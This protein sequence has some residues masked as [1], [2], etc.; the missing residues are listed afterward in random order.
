MKRLD[1]S[2]SWFELKKNLSGN[3]DLEIDLDKVKLSKSGNINTD[4]NFE[5]YI[6]RGGGFRK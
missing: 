6:N 3:A 5:S 2:F 4:E 1:Q